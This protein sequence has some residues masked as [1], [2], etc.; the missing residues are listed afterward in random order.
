V[1][2]IRIEVHRSASSDSTPP[3]C[4]SSSGTGCVIPFLFLFIAALARFL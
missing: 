3:S 1:A 2:K 4:P